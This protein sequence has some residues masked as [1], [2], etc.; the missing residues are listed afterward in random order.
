MQLLILAGKSQGQDF[1]KMRQVGGQDSPWF[2]GFISK[3]LFDNTNYYE[4]Y[5]VLSETDYGSLKQIILQDLPSKTN[6]PDSIEYGVFAIVISE[7]S[8]TDT[9]YLPTW[10][11]SRRYFIKLE[12]Y[13][14]EIHL[15]NN[16]VNLFT[17]YHNRL[18]WDVKKDGTPI[19]YPTKGMRK[20]G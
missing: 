3:F 9:L 14:R 7:K 19:K 6:F 12:G 1:I 8:K 5:Y 10:E 11:E 20:P 16:L 4:R 17:Y 2:V 18:D 13:A 15:D